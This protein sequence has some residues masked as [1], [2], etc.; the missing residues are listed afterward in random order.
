MP[1]ARP[2]PFAPNSPM[3]QSFFHAGARLQ[4][5]VQSDRYYREIDFAVE[6]TLFEAIILVAWVVLS[7]SRVARRAD[8][9][10]GDPGLVW[11]V[12]LPR[13]SLSAFH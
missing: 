13:S 7:S 3:P 9:D 4:H 5:P 10:R 11:W 8:P 6:Q 12:R 1:S 2:Q